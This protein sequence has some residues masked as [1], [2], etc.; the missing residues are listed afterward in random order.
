MRGTPGHRKHPGDAGGTGDPEDAGEAGAVT[1]FVRAEV[2]WNLK[3]CEEH[4]A[5]SGRGPEQK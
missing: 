2:S 3:R 1:M 5:G 4:S